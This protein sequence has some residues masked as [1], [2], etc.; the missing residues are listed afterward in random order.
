MFLEVRGLCGCF[1]PLQEINTFH[2][3]LW[4]FILSTSHKLS[5]VRCW[6]VLGLEISRE[7]K[8]TAE[9]EEKYL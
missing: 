7:T 2:V 5:R 6:S 1:S 3:M 9:K 4:I 8:S